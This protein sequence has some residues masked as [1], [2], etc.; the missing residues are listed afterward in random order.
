MALDRGAGVALWWQIAETLEQEIGRRAYGATGRL[1]TEIEFA[2]RFGVNRHTVRRAIA[3]L[4]EQG[5]V[6]IE[7][8]R[9]TFVQDSVIGYRVGKRTRFRENIQRMQMTPSGELIGALKEPA[10]ATVAKALGLRSG[11]PVVR[12]ETRMRADGQVVSLGVHYFSHRRFPDLIEVFG[13]EGSVTKTFRR[14]GIEDYTRKTTR[15]TARLPHADEIRHL[16]IPK[17]RPV[18]VSEAINVDADDRPLEYG[19]ARFAA[20][21]VQL[22]IES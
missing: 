20:D 15:I 18:L 1:P 10:D 5:L 3:W 13:Q 22:V 14:Y 9:G 17:S 11:S 6:R 19:I 4:Q 7:Q 8:G 2:A 16:E 12:V 21:R